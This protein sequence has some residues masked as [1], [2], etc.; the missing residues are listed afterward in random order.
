[1][2][3]QTIQVAADDDDAKQDNDGSDFAVG[4][5][6]QQCAASTTAANRTILGF[7]F[8]DVQVPPGTTLV[9]ASLSISVF[10]F[11][12]NTDDL[13]CTVEV[14]ADGDALDFTASATITGRTFEAT[15]VAWEALNT[16]SARITSPDISAVMQDYIDDPGYAPGNSVMV[17]IRGVADANRSALIFMHET[18]Q[19]AAASLYL[20]WAGGAGAVGA[21]G[22]ALGRKNGL[23][24]PAGL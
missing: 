3:S 22:V 19:S 15:T 9:A 20:E 21:Q 24:I 16:G 23:H 17:A 11:A 13:D 1:M 4:G 10:E 12:E 6:V 8:H 18:S 2:A 7:V 5:G 14:E